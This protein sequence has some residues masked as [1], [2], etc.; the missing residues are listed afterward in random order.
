ML[1][2]VFVMPR[3]FQA[4]E[5]SLS[6]PLTLNVPAIEPEVEPKIVLTAIDPTTGPWAWKSLLATLARKLS[7]VDI[8]VGEGVGVGVGEGV[9]VGVGVAKAPPDVR[10]PVIVLV[11]PQQAATDTMRSTMAAPWAIRRMCGNEGRCLAAAFGI[12]SIVRR[13]RPATGEA[14]RGRA[15]LGGGRI[16]AIEVKASSAPT[17]DDARHLATMRDRMGESFVAGVVFHTGPRA[18]RLGEGIVAV[19]IIALWA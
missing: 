8:G 5:T 4:I 14:G 6:A 12:T 18:Y 13:S 16:V 10:S 1:S 9:G 7:S 3:I 17:P 19:P 11:V 15:E 2:F